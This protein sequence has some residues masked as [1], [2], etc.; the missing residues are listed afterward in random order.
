MTKKQS[1]QP[2]KKSNPAKNEKKTSF[3]IRKVVI[4]CIALILIAV[5]IIAIPNIRLLFVGQDVDVSTPHE[6]KVIDL[7]FRQDGELDFFDYDGSV[8]T[9]I[10]IE[11]A[12]DDGSRLQG[13]MGRDSMEENQGM[14]FIYYSTGTPRPASMWMKNT[15]IPLDMIFIRQ[16][17]TISEIV[18][19]TV[20]FDETPIISSEP[21][22]YVLEVN[23]GFTRRHGIEPGHKVTWR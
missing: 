8:I 4:F 22:G 10:D 13:L 19:D 6:P 12:D 5:L 7:E 14:L 9:T 20:P 21:I 23:A 15:I 18:E 1:Q 16:D 2:K 3:D 17:K 11:I